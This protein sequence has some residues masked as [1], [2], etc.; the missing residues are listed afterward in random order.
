MRQVPLV[1]L[2]VLLA[3][4]SLPSEATAQP[5]D[6]APL[7]QVEQKLQQVLRL[8]ADQRRRLRLVRR[9][10]RRLLGE[11]EGI[12]RTRDQA[13]R[14][15]TELA[16]ETHQTRSRARGVAAQL[17]QTEHQL[18][19]RR[20]RLGD[21]L[22]EIYKYSRAGFLDIL[23]GA[24]DFASF[25]T[26]W[27]RIAMVVQ[28]DTAV[29]DAYAAD[30]ARSR[31][32]RATLSSDQA[33]LRALTAHARDRRQE[34]A[35][36]E[37]SKRTMLRRIQAERAAYERMVRE[38]EQN[39]HDLGVL[40]RRAQAA[41]LRA[42]VAEAR[43]PFAFAWPSRGAIT[44]GFGL[45]RH[46]LFGIIHLHTGIDIAA[47]WGSPVLAAADGRVIYA[48]WFGGYGKI[49]VIDHGQEVSTLYGHLS[50]W[51]VAVG[52]EVRRGQPIAR[53]GNTGYSNGPHVHFEIRVN[54][55][56]VDPESF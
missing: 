47:V 19:A 46:P 15:L 54:G 16:A 22:R 48:G 44:S 5:I 2:A 45:R 34:I 28:A 23:L 36:Q 30:A 9:Q 24:D 43:T 40:I 35:A 6:A 52:D 32:L 1:A 31:Q 11:L 53:V 27:H 37:R 49:V 3:L 8:L 17:A 33:Y 25:V 50:Q 51:L 14:R 21:R 13:E 42:H 41:P 12:D 20:A 55:T 56:P 4:P 7:Q 10:E 26:H 29:I 18:Q 38:L 39:S